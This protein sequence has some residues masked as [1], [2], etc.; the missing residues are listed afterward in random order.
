MSAPDIPVFKR[1]AQ[2]SRRDQGTVVIRYLG[3]EITIDGEGAVLFGKVYPLL[4][5]KNALEGIARTAS[6][7]P[8]RL[9]ALAGQLE[10]A[11]VLALVGG[12]EAE[13]PQGMSGRAF[14]AL[15]RK[16]SASWLEPVYA[17][18]GRAHV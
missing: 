3:T 15:H 8:T 18:I 7:E 14:Y 13:D 4:D 1:T 11:G 17:Q 16:H 10:R 5:G 9:R 6:V 12:E 2:V